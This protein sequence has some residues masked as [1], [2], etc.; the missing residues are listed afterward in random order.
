MTPTPIPNSSSPGTQVQKAEWALTS[1]SSKIMPT[2]L[3][4]KPTM[5]SHRC[6]CRR[7]NRS[8]PAEAAR[9]PTVAG[10]SISPVSIALKPLTSC[11]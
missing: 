4:R 3:N 11:R 2:T 1:A 9:M 10:V 6:G 8:A 5:M 7:A